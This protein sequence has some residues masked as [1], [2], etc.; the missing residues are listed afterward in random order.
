MGRKEEKGADA[1]RF[2][3][4]AEDERDWRGGG[5]AVD[6]DRRPGSS[7]LSWGSRTWVAA[8]RGWPVSGIRQQWIPSPPPSNSPLLPCLLLQSVASPYV[9]SRVD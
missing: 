9:G 2:P 8:A 4:R 1:E 3:L 6:G 7:S 5:G